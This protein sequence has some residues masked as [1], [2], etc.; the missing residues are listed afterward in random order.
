MPR[1]VPK[2]H[3]HVLDL[4]TSRTPSRQPSSGP[5]QQLQPSQS[6]PLEDTRRS[7]RKRKEATR[8]ESEPFQRSPAKKRKKTDE[9]P[10]TADTQELEEE[11][12]DAESSTDPDFDVKISSKR[13]AIGISTAPPPVTPVAPIKRKKGRQPEQK[14]QYGTRLTEED[15]IVL[16]NMCIARSTKYGIETMQQFWNKIRK[17]FEKAI[18]R[19]Y[20]DVSRRMEDLVAKKKADIR[21]SH[22]SDH[23]ARDDD[24]TQAVDGWIPTF[25]VYQKT[26]D[27]KSSSRKR[28][29]QNN[30]KHEKRRNRLSQRMAD[31]PEYPS[32]SSSSESFGDQN[33]S[34]DSSLDTIRTASGDDAKTSEVLDLVNGPSSPF[35]D[36]IV[37]REALNDNEI[38]SDPFPTDEKYPPMLL[39]RALSIDRST[40]SESFA[41]STLSESIRSAKK[42]P[43]KQSRK[44]SD[45]AKSAHIRKTPKRSKQARV[46]AADNVGLGILQ[47][48]LS[49]YF[50]S[51][52]P[53]M[54]DSAEQRSL[55]RKIE[56]MLDKNLEKMKRIYQEQTEE[57]SR[58]FDN[59]IAHIGTMWQEHHRTQF[60]P[61][62]CQLEKEVDA[63]RECC[64]TIIY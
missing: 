3:L 64:N 47:Q 27:Q 42:R 43:A 51:Q 31:K 33:G 62:F 54:E 35:D 2:S 50:K 8:F 61:V 49:D 46:G 44:S 39:S 22:K 41:L 37:M 11:E 21:A 6:Q 28:K 53:P 30:A 32:T 38:G 26:K 48:A 19:K 12:T 5:S 40:S 10:Q 16:A 55:L 34:D 58:I 45:S 24:W 56:S 1:G 63:V 4:G 7:P 36:D 25:V 29:I 9:L 57:A 23:A 15:D 52:M 20:V 14:L 13:P 17:R 60:I 18:G 59:E